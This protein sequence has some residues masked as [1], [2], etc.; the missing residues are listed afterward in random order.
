[1]RVVVQDAHRSCVFVASP[2]GGNPQRCCPDETALRGI[3]GDPAR[4]LRG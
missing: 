3:A 1:M 4:A 2:D